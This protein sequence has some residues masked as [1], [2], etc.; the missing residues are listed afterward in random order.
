VVVQLERREGKRGIGA[1]AL[2][3]DLL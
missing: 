1:I 2:S 3:R